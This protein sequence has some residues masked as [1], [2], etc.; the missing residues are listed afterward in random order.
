MKKTK[1]EL[2]K[3][4]IE[5]IDKRREEIFSIGDSIYNE[6]ELGTRSLKQQK[7]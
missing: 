3:M 7:K 1:E 2:K 5:A 6:P 4:A